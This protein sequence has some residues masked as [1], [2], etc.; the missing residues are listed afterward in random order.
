[1]KQDTKLEVYGY[2][3]LTHFAKHI[4][5]STENT[6]LGTGSEDLPETENEPELSELWFN[7]LEKKEK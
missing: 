7:L 3:I 1:M 4:C 5:S 6:F 2:R